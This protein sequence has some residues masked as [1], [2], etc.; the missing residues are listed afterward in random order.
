MMMSGVTTS[1]KRCET[2]ARS[3]ELIAVT[4]Q[5]VPAKKVNQAGMPSR[6][7][8]PQKNPCKGQYQLEMLPFWAALRIA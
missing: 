5:T 7:R 8:R 1:A 4:K 6:S 2:R 3:R